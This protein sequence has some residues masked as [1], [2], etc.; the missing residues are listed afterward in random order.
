VVTGGFLFALT[1]FTAVSWATGG[2]RAASSSAPAEPAKTWIDQER[3]RVQVLGARAG[4]MEA[5]LAAKKQNTLL[6]RMLVTN[7]ADESATSLEF[8]RGITAQSGP[9][10]PANRVEDSEI[11][12]AG[13]R[14]GYFHPRIPVQ[15]DLIWPLPN[16]IKLPRVTISL[17]RW[18]YVEN[19]FSG[20]DPYWAMHKDAPTVATVTLPVQHGATS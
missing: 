7:M 13:G 4:V 9:G 12:V 20:A 1:I 6:V 18:E 10:R 17:R 11:V 5:G 3:F 2:L 16:D 14:E 15:V 19:P 8:G